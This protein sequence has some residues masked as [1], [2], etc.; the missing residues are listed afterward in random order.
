[1]TAAKMNYSG[2]NV[3]ISLCMCVLSVAVNHH[4][5]WLTDRCRSGL[6]S[7]AR[8][9]M[10]P[11]N[12]SQGHSIHSHTRISSTLETPVGLMCRPVKL[13]AAC[14]TH[15]GGTC[16]SNGENF[17]SFLDVRSRLIQSHYRNRRSDTST[18]LLS[19][20]RS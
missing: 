6:S 5:W 12:P 1:M 19:A 18:H 17:T 11:G 9:K 15:W 3:Q 4:L 13:A 2:A 20:T 14:R 10:Q 7:Q 8:G 16:D